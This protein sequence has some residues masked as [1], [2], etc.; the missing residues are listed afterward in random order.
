MGAATG[1][2]AIGCIIAGLL[3]NHTGRKPLIWIGCVLNF[4]GIGLQ[5]ASSEWKL[6]LVARLIHGIGF[7][8]TYTFSPV[9]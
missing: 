9:W 8:M 5:Q 4:V 2:A 3:M 6:F 7:A 1:G